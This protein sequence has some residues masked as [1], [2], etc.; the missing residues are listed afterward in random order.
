[1]RADNERQK[2]KVRNRNTALGII[3]GAGAVAIL[4]AVMK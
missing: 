2:K 4:V 1:M 3:S